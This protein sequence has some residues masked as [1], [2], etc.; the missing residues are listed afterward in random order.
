MYYQNN[1]SILTDIKRPA[2]CLDI[3]DFSR[4][5]RK[6][7]RIFLNRNENCQF[8][9]IIIAKISK[10]FLKRINSNKRTLPHVFLETVSSVIFSFLNNF[11]FENYIR[12]F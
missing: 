6:V 12:T 4:R 10:R 5:F 3:F 7:S 9:K 8:D 11:K 1:F 2:N